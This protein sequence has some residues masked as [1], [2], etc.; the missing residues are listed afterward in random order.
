MLVMHFGHRHSEMHSHDATALWAAIRPASALSHP[1]AVRQG[2]HN[3]AD[4]RLTNARTPTGA[5]R[6]AL[7]SPN[8]A[9]GV[10]VEVLQRVSSPAVAVEPRAAL[11]SSQAR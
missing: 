7:G 8:K 1:Y 3:D 6:R 9:D 10:F 5:S 2:S 11:I 4:A